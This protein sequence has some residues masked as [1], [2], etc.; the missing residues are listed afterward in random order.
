MLRFVPD[1]D[2]NRAWLSY[3]D[4][5]T[6][7]KSW[8]LPRVSS[9]DGLKDLT[10]DQRADWI[11]IA[12]GQLAVPNTLGAGFPEDEMRGFYGFN[13]FDVDRFML[14]GN[15]PDW[16]TIVDFGFD[17]SQIAS[18]LTASGYSSQTLSNSE[19]LYSILDDYETDIRGQS[20][21][22]RV[23]MVGD[24]NRI[25]LLDGRM[26]IGKAT[27]PVMESLAASQGKTPSLADDPS[28]VAAVK[29]LDDPVLADMGDLVGVIMLD[30]A[31][32]DQP[33]EVSTLPPDTVNQIIQGYGAAPLP[34][35]NL[36]T[37]ATRHGNGVTHLILE[38]VF[39]QGVDAKAAANILVDRMNNYI[40]LRTGK[41][42][43]DRWTFD[44]STGTK[45]GGLPTALVVMKVAD[46]PPTPVGQ[47]ATNVTVFSWIVMMY[48][49]D[50]L[51]LVSQH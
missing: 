11:Y 8:N 16:I 20:V 44:L 13:M 9:F 15:P 46:P 39:P 23:G 19:T 21:K 17:K 43:A 3:G 33:Q 49:R 14:A 40:S 35:Y 7:R 24:L 30:H 32:V 27:D 2:N 5:A 18:A 47:E 22:T 29:S 51:F 36:V 38:V 28:Y 10:P 45:I 1:T 41:P 37:F 26:V 42:L 25:A 4:I 50:T 48:A 31:Q 34:Q 6:W 12:S